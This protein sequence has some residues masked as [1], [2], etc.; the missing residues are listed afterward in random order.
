MH[1]YHFG[2]SESAA[3]S[4]EIFDV[5]ARLAERFATTA[6]ARDKQGGTPKVERDAIRESGLLGL[7]IP[8]ELGGLEASWAVTLKVVRHLARVD[9]SVAHVFG[10]HHLLLATVR[11]FGS[12]EQYRTWSAETTRDRLYWGNALNPL[13]KRTTLTWKGDTAFIRGD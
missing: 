8:R 11:L 9:G 2:K 13:D 1:A 4:R 12:P 10:F 7:S 5:T 6:V 3:D